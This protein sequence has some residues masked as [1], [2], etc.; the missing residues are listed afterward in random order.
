M[1]TVYQS[2]IEY[3]LMMLS[4]AS[5]NVDDQQQFIPRSIDASMRHIVADQTSY[6]RT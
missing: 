5:S 3:R 2:T 1:H 6:R 4:V